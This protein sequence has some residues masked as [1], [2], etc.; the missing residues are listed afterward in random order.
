MK[1]LLVFLS[2][3]L[4]SSAAYTQRLHAGVFGGLSAYNGALTEQIFPRK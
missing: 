1:K 4:L 3:A 2:L